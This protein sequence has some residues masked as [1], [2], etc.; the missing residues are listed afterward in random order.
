MPILR[1]DRYW[2][3]PRSRGCQD[4]PRR[5]CRSR[6]DQTRSSIRMGGAMGR[7]VS[8]PVHSSRRRRRRRPPRTGRRSTMPGATRRQI[9][10]SFERDPL[11]R[12]DEQDRQEGHGIDDRPVAV[13]PTAPPIKPFGSDDELRDESHGQRLERRESLIRPRG[14]EPEQGEEHEWRKDE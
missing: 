9:R 5:T 7:S 14:D 13:A 2:P 3:A 6:A 1:A 11:D 8:R 10:R 12:G 4:S